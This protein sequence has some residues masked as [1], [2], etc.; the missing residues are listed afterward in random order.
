MSATHSALSDTGRLARR[1]DTAAHAFLLHDRAERRFGE[2]SV[3]LDAAALV[4]GGSRIRAT[5][6]AVHEQ[7]TEHERVLWRECGAEIVAQPLDAYADALSA[8][9][10]PR[11]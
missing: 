11:R 8:W 9:P 3:F 4:P 1:N 6:W 2:D 7:A 5:S 10:H